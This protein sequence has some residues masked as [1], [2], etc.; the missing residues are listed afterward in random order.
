M[1]GVKDTFHSKKDTNDG[2]NRDWLRR[3]LQHEAPEFDAFIDWSKPI[4]V[5][6]RRRVTEENGQKPPEPKDLFTVEVVCLDGNPTVFDFSSTRLESGAVLFGDLQ[7][8][9][10]DEPNNPGATFPVN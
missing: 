1:G 10:D 4:Q 6:S 7:W 8:G 9:T 2:L 5:V 3:F